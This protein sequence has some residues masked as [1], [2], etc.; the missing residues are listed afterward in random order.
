MWSRIISTGIVGLIM[1]ACGGGGNGSPVSQAPVTPPVTPPAPIEFNRMPSTAG[2]FYTQKTVQIVKYADGREEPATTYS[3]EFVSEQNSTS[4]STITTNDNLYGSSVARIYDANGKLTH[5]SSAASCPTSFVPAVAPGLPATVRLDATWETKYVSTSV[6]TLSQASEQVSLTGKVLG[7]ETVTTAAGTF[8]TIKYAIKKTVTSPTRIL[9]IEE[10]CWADPNSGVDVKCDS[11]DVETAL[12]A[13]KNSSTATVSTEL[14]AYS[15]A[16]SNRRK[17]GVERFAGQWK[18]TYVG[19]SQGGV[20]L[21]YV[22][23]PGQLQ[24]S[25]GGQTVSG[26]VDANGNVS[27][28]LSADGNSVQT[29]KGGAVSPGAMS[30]S[31]LLPDGSGGT[32]GMTH[33]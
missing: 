30:G 16:T 8:S 14:I 6:C 19:N 18:G 33:K 22:T 2:D 5:S 20:C 4:Y 28:V 3:T 29:F 24:G 12:V 21:F 1:S 17:L 31:W 26:A 9:V 32:W 27:F 10:T 23:L 25:C 15:H 11:A 7:Q 13:P